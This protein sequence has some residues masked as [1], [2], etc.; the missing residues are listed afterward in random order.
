MWFVKNYRAVSM[1]H[2]TYPTL[3]VVHFV[4][5]VSDWLSSV[6]ASKL[7]VT[8]VRCVCYL[9][10][11]LFQDYSHRN[12]SWVARLQRC[13]RSIFGQ[14]CGPPHVRTSENKPSPLPEH[15]PQNMLQHL[16]N[17]TI[18]YVYQIPT[19]H[20]HATVL[21]VSDCNLT[22]SQMKAG[23]GRGTQALK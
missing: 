15:R 14:R 6:S 8:V 19:V 12:Y 16:L 22:F 4:P 3:G 2:H 13:S 9:V 21:Y 1:Q 10:L 18:C 7:L 11:Y 20:N 17:C 23:F 5:T